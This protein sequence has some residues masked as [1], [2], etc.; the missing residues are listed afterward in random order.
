MDLTEE[1]LRLPDNYARYLGGLRWAPG[2]DA[3]D[4]AD[5]STYAFSFQV[6]AFLE[7]YI[8]HGPLIHYGH[9][10]HLLDFLRRREGP[11]DGT[12]RRQVAQAFQAGG[13]SHRNAGAFFAAVCR[14]LPPYPGPPVAD[15]LWRLQYPPSPFPDP[16]PGLASVGVAPPQPPEW[17]EAYVCRALAAYGFDDL[18]HWFRHGTG[19][20][21]DAAPLAEAVA[22][23]PASL[24]AVLAELTRS[25]R[26][27]GAVPYVGR[28]AGAL[29]LPRRRL[30]SHELPL[31]GY[32]DVTTRGDMAQVLPA[33]L[34]LD[35]DEFVRR[36]AQRELLFFR[37]EEPH[38]S[39]REEL[40]VLL[41]QGVRTWGVVRLMLA[42]AALALGRFAVR[43]RL[44]LR[45]AATSG[46][47]TVD[48]LEADGEDLAALVGASDLSPHPGAA[49]ERVL[50][51][52]TPPCDVVLLTHPR[53]LAEPD[54]TAAARRVPAGARL[55][56]LTVT[57]AGGAELSE[58]RH[59][60]PVSLSRFR[61]EAESAPAPVA[62]AAAARSAPG[63]WRG[64]VEP[65]PYPFRFGSHNH[66]HRLRFAFDYA[67]EWL[68]LATV[69][70]VL[71]ATRTD[72][73]GS[74]V[75][76]RPFVGNAVLREVEAVV[77]VAGGFVV[78]GTIGRRL[79][80]AHYDIESR[81]CRVYEAGVTAELKEP[82]AWWYARH[83]HAAVTAL[84]TRL[85]CLDLSAGKTAFVAGRGPGAVPARSGRY[86][87]CP[88]RVPGGRG[89]ELGIS[90][91]VVQDA[92]ATV[93]ESGGF[94]D[95]PYLAL[96]PR[97]GSLG[98]GNVPGWGR[99]TPL[100]DG[101]PMLTGCNL[102][103]ADCRGPTL[104]ALVNDPR[105]RP[106]GHVLRVFR[107]PEGVPAG[108]F[109]FR[110]TPTP[111]TLS[112]DG[113]LL[114]LPV[115]PSRVE[116]RDA[117]VRGPARCVTPV[118]RFHNAV[119]V[120]LGDGWLALHNGVVLHLARWGAGRL[121]AEVVR[122][123]LP[124]AG[125]GIEARSNKLPPWLY[126]GQ[127][128][129]KVA[130]GWLVAAVDRFG[131]VALFE[132]DGRLVGMFFT[133]RHQFAAWT[134]DGTRFGPK[135]LLGVP[136]TPGAAEKIG[137]ALKEAGERA[138]RRTLV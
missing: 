104:A 53:N 86:Q 84:G 44:K 87:F 17:F 2:G 126:D 134:P 27:A 109:P 34:A 30:Q 10:L 110:V 75:W 63:E 4:L 119:R 80:A 135:A 79:V 76:P 132:R 46:S 82:Q 42:A 33:Q 136:P 138:G 72:G 116:V 21:R 5:G 125:G 113:R 130:H 71:C 117:L 25:P 35:G 70:G 48:P 65:V 58:V 29:A 122:G 83:S 26:L 38:A 112:D 103:E 62:A 77:G 14:D 20:V 133:L 13:R 85:W 15:L 24:A 100:A 39:N 6:G 78:A 16:G 89:A 51:G 1:Y 50:E 98:V 95:W 137:A 37:R 19:A 3:V 81:A 118:G 64:D 107:G 7:G 114:A 61:V 41:D 115:D 40:V 111:F 57:A 67:G 124:G 108:E 99:F 88:L 127:R 68:L 93:P 60:S 66:H 55:F 47:A 128:F 73:S 102:V 54:V 106:P 18:L 101:R 90:F 56:A 59:G 120:E 52:A 36:F 69:Q 22:A 129:V 11:P 12:V 43:R 23:R 97:D 45:V 131:Q 28:F 32:D 31:G 91:E 121:T 9:V 94:P 8:A 96:D 123:M 105:A 74:E 92:S 49:L